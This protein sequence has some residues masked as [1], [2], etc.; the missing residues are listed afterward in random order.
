LRQMRGTCLHLSN[1]KK[2]PYMSHQRNSNEKQ[3]RLAE[4]RKIMLFKFEFYEK[5]SGDAIITHAEE[6][7][8]YEK[9]LQKLRK[10]V[11]DITEDNSYAVD[12]DEWELVDRY[13]KLYEKTES[14]KEYL[15]SL[16]EM[17][18]VYLF[19]SLEVVLKRIIQTAYPETN[20]KELWQWD[21][22]KIFF[23]NYD[24]EIAKLDGY[25][26]S[27]QLRLVN[28][29]IK[30]NN[31]LNGEIKKIGEFKNENEFSHINLGAFYNR[32]R[33]KVENFSKQ[34]RDKVEE[35]LYDFPIKRLINLVD[36]YYERMDNATFVVF[37]EKLKEKIA[38]SSNYYSNESFDELPF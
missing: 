13:S 30:H 17:K 22:I 16:S 24:I 3:T 35:D 8:K 18:I 26:E 1:F 27:S 9:E 20:I 6:L 12:Q 33:P 32:I 5:A 14:T 34:I 4:L 38:C 28:N 21:T 36:E 2:Y 23:K 31:L 29:S 25:I 15:L 11:P 7:E 10:N 19:K 37:I